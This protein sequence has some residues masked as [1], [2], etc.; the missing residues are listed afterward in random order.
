MRGPTFR[1]AL[2]L[3]LVA[4]SGL[5][6]DSTAQPGTDAAYRA[7][8]KLAYHNHAPVGPLPPTLDPRLFAD[9]PTAFVAYSLAAQIENV[10]FQEPCYCPCDKDQ[11]HQSLLD[12]FTSTH[13]VGCRECQKELF[14]C[15]QKYKEGRSPRQIRKAM[16]Q[17]S[18]WNFDLT[19]TVSRFYHELRRLR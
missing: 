8:K 3:L 18:T 1:I 13:G 19:K 9:D 7:G 4:C 16:A 12:C 5:F 2:S 10:L 17:D 6:A 14:I 11:N 15:F